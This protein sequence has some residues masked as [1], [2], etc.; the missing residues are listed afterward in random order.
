M[1][2]P[3]EA[4]PLRVSVHSDGTEEENTDSVGEK[5]ALGVT[6]VYLV[7]FAAG[8]LPPLVALWHPDE[9]EIDEGGWSWL[10]ANNL[11]LAL[12]LLWTLLHIDNG[13]SVAMACLLCSLL[14]VYLNVLLLSQA[15]RGK[16][17]LGIVDG[18]VHEVFH[19][20][21]L[22]VCLRAAWVGV[23]E[24]SHKAKSDGDAT[25]RRVFRKWALVSASVL[26]L[27]VFVACW[28]RNLPLT[29]A[30]SE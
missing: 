2:S 15:Y 22:W 19:L 30:D 12:A 17:P 6:A 1:S 13:P 21:M 24:K 20:V 4:L 11:W 23:A 5:V 18:V 28:A 25:W 26:L 14:W 16:L 8:C 29:P 10:G 27:A 7:A 3:E 9:Q